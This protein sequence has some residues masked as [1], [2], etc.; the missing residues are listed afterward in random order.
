MK[1]ETKSTKE[2]L[3]DTVKSVEKLNDQIIK[4]AI[5]YEGKTVPIKTIRHDHKRKRKVIVLDNNDGT[6]LSFDKF[7]ND[8]FEL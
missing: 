3:A 5:I 6:I 4:L 2:L 7:A 1:K 8:V